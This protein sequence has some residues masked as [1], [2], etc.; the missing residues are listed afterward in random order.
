M[1]DRSRYVDSAENFY[2]ATRPT[3]VDDL[4]RSLMKKKSAVERI[5]DTGEEGSW[6]HSLP[7]VAE[8]IRNAGLSNVVVSLEFNPPQY[9]QRRA[10]VVLSGYKD[11]TPSVLVIELKQWSTATW[12]PTNNWVSE[13]AARYGKVEHPVRQAYGYAQMVQHY[14]EGFHSEEA[15]VEAAAYLHNAT[16]YSLQSLKSAGQWYADRLFSGDAAGDAAF[17]AFLKDRFDNING[18]VVAEALENNDPRMSKD[19]LEAAGEIFQNPGSFPLSEEQREVINDIQ[20]KFTDAL[21]PRNPRGKTIIVV[22]GKP[23]SGKTWICMN[24]LGKEA[25]AGR[26]V[27]FATN[28]T[29][30]RET[31]KKVAN[32]SKE[33]KPVSAMITSARTYWKE[34]MW[35]SRDLLIVDEAQRIN[36]WTVRTGQRNRKDIQEELERFNMTQLREL[37]NSA[38]VLVLMMDDLQQTTANDYLTTEK[39][40]EVADLIGADFQLYELEEQHR[41]GGSKTFEAWVDS[42]V[43]DVP[44]VW[45]DEE[46]FWVKVADSP[47]EM[48]RILEEHS[49]EDPRIM[50]GFCWPWTT[51]DPETDKPF[52]HV[53]DV[54]YDIVIGDWSIQWNLKNNAEG[55]PKADLWAFNDKGA[56]QAGWDCCASS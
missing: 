25:S 17:D 12:D 54:P 7:R 45:H 31:L 53:D 38:K 9:G 1:A 26:Q 19:I 34:E 2:N 23:G 18:R 10:D 44:T 6:K 42:L 43:D 48:E 21:D 50:A 33:T 46:N 16:T 14:I 4:I 22:N 13:I 8:V 27:A 37:A 32:R 24:L 49:A 41:S 20:K 28:S 39:V 56:R 29:S 35:G 47:E 40:K 36:E 51:K 52:R 15:S 30:L 55:Y 11:G 3:A 5:N